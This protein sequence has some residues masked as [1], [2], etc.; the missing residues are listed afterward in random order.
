MCVLF[1]P[2]IL[3]RMPMIVGYL[4]PKVSNKPGS[5]GYQASKYHFSLQT[6]CLDFP[7]QSP[8]EIHLILQGPILAPSHESHPGYKQI[9][10]PKNFRRTLTIPQHTRYAPV[11]RTSWTFLSSIRPPALK[12]VNAYTVMYLLHTQSCLQ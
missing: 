6:K 4:L 5:T 12:T 11:R 10:P 1:C 7:K 3:T 9:L 2:S 8:A